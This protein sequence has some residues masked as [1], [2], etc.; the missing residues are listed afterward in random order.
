VRRN[1][2]TAAT[3]CTQDGLDAIEEWYAATKDQALFTAIVPTPSINDFILATWK[4]YEYS[5]RGPQWFEVNF[6]FEETRVQ[7]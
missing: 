2:F 6:Q 3:T 4:S 7:W 1:N 5:K